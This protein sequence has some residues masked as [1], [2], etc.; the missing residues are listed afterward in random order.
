MWM[1]VAVATLIIVLV[2]VVVVVIS[3][4]DEEE[5]EVDYSWMQ[6]VIDNIVHPLWEVALKDG[7]VGQSG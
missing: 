7:R 3:E 5:K 4:Q 1:L 2:V 6:F